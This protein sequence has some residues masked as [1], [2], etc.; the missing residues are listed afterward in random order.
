MV[1]DES[2]QPAAYE[3]PPPQELPVD[4]ESKGPERSL[5]ESLLMRNA[6][7]F[8]KLRW[9]VIATLVCYGVLGLFPGVIGY[10]GLRSPGRWPFVMAG[11]LTLFNL[12]FLFF[13]RAGTFQTRI[14]FNLWG[15]II[16]DLAVITAVIYFVGS[17]ETSIAFTYLFHIVLS[18]VFFSHK[19]SLIVTLM[20]I[21]IFT[22]CISAFKCEKRE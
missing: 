9:L 2:M 17:L 19:Q 20:A 7:W 10:F 4:A 3:L 18:C 15:Q 21:G 1:S 14:I 22:V 5:P 13:A 8:C 12:A 16:A 11:V 6:L